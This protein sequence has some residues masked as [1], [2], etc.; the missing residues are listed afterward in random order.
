MVTTGQ[1]F[2][3]LLCL[4]PSAD[5]RNN[6]IIY[7]VLTD[8]YFVEHHKTIEAMKKIMVTAGQMHCVFL[9]TPSWYFQV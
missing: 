5:N 1:Y 4:R 9:K 8:V 2:K 7:C 3:Y 6:D